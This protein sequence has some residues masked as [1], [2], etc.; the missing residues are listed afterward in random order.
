MSVVD[1]KKHWSG[2]T[3]PR[4]KGGVRQYAAVYFARTDDPQDQSFV[5]AQYFEDTVELPSI[6]DAY[7]YGND[8]DPVAVCVEIDPQPAGQN[9]WQVVCSYESSTPDTPSGNDEDGNPTDDPLLM[10]CEVDVSIAKFT[11]P[12]ERAKIRGGFAGKA[13]DAWPLG[14]EIKPMNSAGTVIV[15]PI[16]KDVARIVLRVSKNEALFPRDEALAYQDAVNNDA[17]LLTCRVGNVV[18]VIAD[19]DQYQGKVEG[20][21][22]RLRLGPTGAYWNVTREVHINRNGWRYEHLDEGIHFAARDGDDDLRGGKFGAVDD[23]GDPV[24]GVV[25]LAG[26]PSVVRA[27]DAYGV[28]IDEPVPLDGDGAP[29]DPGDALVWLSFQIYDELPFANFGIN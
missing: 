13:L 19:L 1:H 24:A 21:S 14:T 11:A 15:P 6:G 9:Y 5:V 7:V 20:V 28:P 22:G 16:E 27:V 26:R 12:V 17:L 4:R 23:N 2:S 3:G 29:L 18:H 25:S 8:N 10:A